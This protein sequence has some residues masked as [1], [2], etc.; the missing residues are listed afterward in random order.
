MSQSG[1]T[2]AF[3]QIK[4]VCVCPEE[5]ARRLRSALIPGE[6][7]R[8]RLPARCQGLAMRRHQH[9]VPAASAQRR[10]SAQRRGSPNP[11]GEGSSWP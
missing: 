4:M 9:S 7:V 5:G 2:D 11:G 1:R 8:D 3:V 6:G 10:E